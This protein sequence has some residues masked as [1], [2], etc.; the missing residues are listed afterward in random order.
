V[1]QIGRISA[2]GIAIRGNGWKASALKPGTAAKIR[3]GR[4]RAAIRRLKYQEA[5]K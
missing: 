3:E 5:G 2:R 4:L 1:I